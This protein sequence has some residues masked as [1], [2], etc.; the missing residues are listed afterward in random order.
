MAYLPHRQPACAGVVHDLR[1]DGRLDCAKP[2]PGERADQGRNGYV[3][4]RWRSSTEFQSMISP[5]M[6]LALARMVIGLNV[7]GEVALGEQNRLIA[8]RPEQRRLVGIM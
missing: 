5:L 6:I 8:H 4:A 7:S 3:A 1:G 2:H